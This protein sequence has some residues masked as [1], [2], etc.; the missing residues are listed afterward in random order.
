[1][2]QIPAEIFPPGEF[3]RDEMEARGWT[4]DDLANVL[5]R[6]RRLVN[7]L[8]SGKKL[9]TPETA[10][11]LGGAFGTGPEFWM[12]LES[13]YRLSLEEKDTSDVARRARLYEKAPIKDLLRRHWIEETDD[14]EGLERSVCQFYEIDSLD[15]EPTLSIAAKKSTDYGVTTPTQ[16]AWCCRARKLARAVHAKE[17]NSTNFR[18]WLPRLR[19][20]LGYPEDVRHVPRVLSEMGIRFVVV[21]H[22]PRTGLDGA[23]FWLSR[24]QPVIVVSCRY[25]RIDNFWFVLGHELAHVHNGDALSVDENL[26]GENAQPTGEKPEIE[27]HADEFSCNFLVPK[28]EM[29]SFVARV[30]PL[31]SKQKINQFANRMKVHPGIIVGQLQGRDAIKYSHSREMLVKVRGELVANALTD[32]WGASPPVK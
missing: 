6:P 14:V 7:E 19:E 17:F 10:R 5:G 32:G 12:N 2:S 22:L 26:V 30:R 8:L 18:Q 13:M 21:E 9:I 29:D 31:F 1:M 11:E 28:R 15:E 24:E 3:I 4:Q 16:M 27:R 20:L 23:T 25:D